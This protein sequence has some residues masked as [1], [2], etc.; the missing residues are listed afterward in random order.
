MRAAA[1]QDWLSLQRDSAAQCTNRPNA[2]QTC[3]PNCLLGTVS[4]FQASPYI[5]TKGAGSLWGWRPQCLHNESFP[6]GQVAPEKGRI[7]ETL[8]PSLQKATCS[9]P[10]Q[11]RKQLGRSNVRPHCESWP[12]KVAGSLS[13]CPQWLAL[14]QS[15]FLKSLGK[16]GLQ[17]MGW[18]I[19]CTDS[20]WD[21]RQTCSVT[22]NPGKS[23]SLAFCFQVK[24]ASRSPAA[25]RNSPS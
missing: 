19:H 25:R 24:M 10:C 4:Q 11:P 5:D 22:S 20:Y 12:Q 2:R 7:C 15:W 8:G 6:V 21:E 1:S 13:A 3:D 18:P 9:F 14:Q 16:R 17:G 23:H